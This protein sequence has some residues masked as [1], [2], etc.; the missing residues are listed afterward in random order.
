MFGDNDRI[1]EMKQK[2]NDVS[3]SFCMAKWMHCTIH[4]LTGHTHSCYL[5]PTHK[6]PLD[7]VKK[8]PSALHNT[9]YKKKMRKMMLEGER[10]S[11][12][13]IC[14]G[15][16]DLPGDNY[17]DRHYRGVE[18][19][20]MPYFDKVKKMQWN[21]NINPTYVE[22]SWSSACNFKCMYCSPMIST[23][24]MK[25]IKKHGSYKLSENEHQNLDWF[26][27]QGLM[28]IDE[29]ENPYI[30]AFWKWWPDLVKDLRHFRITGGEPLL[31]KHTYKTLEL[32]N[33]NPQQEL[34]LSI[35][36]NL[37]IPRRQFERFL[38]LAVPIIRDKKVKNLTLHTSLDTYGKQAE[39]I[40]N[41]L[42]I[43]L[44]EEYLEEYLTAHE[45]TTV[46]F[47]C[48]FNIL[49][50]T[51]FRDFLKR[52]LELKQKHNTDELRKVL[53]DLPH[54][55]APE[56]FACKILTDDYHDIMESHIAFMRDNMDRQYG[57]TEAEV[58]KMK[59]ILQWMKEFND[60]ELLNKYRRDFYLFTKQHDER[61]GTNFLET[62]PEMEDFYDLCESLV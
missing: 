60:R 3:P 4:F 26:K 5:P 52:M 58:Q 62:F 28:P 12:C 57:F 20:T 17:S 39:Y 41:G 38:N 6:I 1:E 7:E 51:G 34:E 10:P 21:E 59:R 32:L 35:N 14:W 47:M 8:D 44:M 46:A 31:S 22:V 56:M 30:E 15:I 23:E 50:V 49:S 9:S 16:E 19:W 33:E 48:T 45:Y 29:N 24:W 36:S 61:R 53:I 40:R 18:N 42:K 13:S 55:Q 43:E 54:L 37:G 11:E 25:E 2:L 27:K